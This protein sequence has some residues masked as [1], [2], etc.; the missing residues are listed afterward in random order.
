MT[1]MVL[2]P[3]QV[4]Q[5]TGRKRSSAQARVLRKQG[6]RFTQDASGHVIVLESEVAARLSAPQPLW[7]RRVALQDLEQ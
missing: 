7:N 1:A 4:R 3:E 6:I 2:T 5:L